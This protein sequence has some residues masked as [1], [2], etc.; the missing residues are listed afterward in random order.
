MSLAR[1]KKQESILEA[2]EADLHELL[3]QAL[4]GVVRS[5]DMLFFN[6]ENL[7]P[8]VQPHWLP[9]ES[10]AALDLATTCI[11]LREE[12]GKPILGT[13]GQLFLSACNEAANSDNE[14]R[15]GP[16]QLAAW[17]LEELK[18]AR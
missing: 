11:S 8:E 6:A 1:L 7:P 13:V 4:P 2:T 5:G 12:L 10:Q 14:H 18:A 16:R 15:R 3:A 17:L 9:K